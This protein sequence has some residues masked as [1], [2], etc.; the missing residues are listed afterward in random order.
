MEVSCFEYMISLA[1]RARLWIAGPWPRAFYSRRQASA[2]SK[3]CPLTL[4]LSRRERKPHVSPFVGGDEGEGQNYSLTLVLCV[5]QCRTG[6]AQPTN[7]L[8]P[9]ESG[10][11]GGGIASGK[12]TPWT[13][14]LDA[15]DP[16]YPFPRRPGCGRASPGRFRQVFG[17]AGDGLIEAALLVAAASRS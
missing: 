11:I 16:T 13:G 15:T 12:Q 8:Q 10:I 4:A 7:I 5:Q 14:C 17:L 1:G 2:H 3:Y 9:C 6:R